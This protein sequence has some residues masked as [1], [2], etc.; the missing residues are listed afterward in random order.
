MHCE[1]GAHR[2]RGPK[3]YRQSRTLGIPGCGQG[4]VLL[5]TSSHCLALPALEHTMYTR[6]GSN[7][8]QRMQIGM[9]LHSRA[10]KG[11]HQPALEV[12]CHTG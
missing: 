1:K 5:E 10:L 4:F 6:L 12:G 9:H 2:I 8:M 7:S 3:L 11:H